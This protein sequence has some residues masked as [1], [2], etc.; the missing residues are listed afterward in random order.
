MMRRSLALL[1]PALLAPAQDAP[2]AQRLRTER[3][4]VERLMEAF[5][6]KEALAK[7]EAL[8]PAQKPTWDNT[9]GNAQYR[10]YLALQDVAAAYYLASR[11]ALA[12][13]LWEK[14]LDHAKGAQATV[15]DNAA[16]AGLAFPKIAEIYEGRA[17]RGREMLVENDAYIKELRAKANPDAGD[18]QQLDLVAAEEKGIAENDKWAK[19]FQGFLDAAKKDA[20]RYD[21]WVKAL[22]DQLKA[23]EAQIAEYKGGKGDKVKWVEGIISSPTYLTTAYPDKR[24]RVAFLYRLAVLD[25]ESAKVQRQIDIE[26]GKIVAPPAKP[27]PKKKGKG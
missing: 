13:G 18:K 8:L 10:S 1:L 25:P 4:E 2:L 3:P 15:A 11:A 17:K 23:V 22:D 7:A 21:P 20:S 5:Q 16:Q 24:E 14:A 26:L 19:T 9:D 12:A 6:A 27:A